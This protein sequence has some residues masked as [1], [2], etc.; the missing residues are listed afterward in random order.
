MYIYRPTTQGV[1]GGIYKSL[2]LSF[3]AST[4]KCVGAATSTLAYCSH[5]RTPEK[6]GLSAIAFIP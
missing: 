3:E 5:L 6:A 1:H 4:L 2:H